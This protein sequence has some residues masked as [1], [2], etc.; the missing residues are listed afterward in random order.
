MRAGDLSR[1]ITIQQP[2]SVK[3]NGLISTS[4]LTFRTVQAFIK[5]LKG[6]ERANAQAVWPGA[7]F[8][9]T[10]R[11][12]RGITGNMRIVDDRGMIYSILGQPNDL[13]GMH[14]EIELTCQSGV[15]AN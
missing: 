12:I 2:A 13:A 9:I 15:K 11:Y 3:T 14:V 5:Q 7:D 8:S 10:I 1:R 4:W 6:Y